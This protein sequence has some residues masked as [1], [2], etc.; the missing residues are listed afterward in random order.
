VIAIPQYPVPVQCHRA[1]TSSCSTGTIER[2][3]AAETSNRLEL[4]LGSGLQFIRINGTVVGAGIGLL[5]HAIAV[6]VS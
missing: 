3:D 1:S 6:S 4:L 2:W 5:L